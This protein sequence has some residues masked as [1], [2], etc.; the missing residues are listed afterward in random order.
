MI[1]TKG[2]SSPVK[3]ICLCEQGLSPREGYIPDPLV[4]AFQS[5]VWE[6]RRQSLTT[7]AKAGVRGIV[8]RTGLN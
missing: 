4:R 5:F 6:P 7:L 8:N 3:T 2:S 1:S